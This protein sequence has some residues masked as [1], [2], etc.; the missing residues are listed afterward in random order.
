M[1]YCYLINYKITIIITE[2]IR[3]FL[4]FPTKLFCK[5]IFTLKI[6]I[7]KYRVLKQKF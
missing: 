4:H 6:Y 2:K 7:K 5:I 1:G 3:Y